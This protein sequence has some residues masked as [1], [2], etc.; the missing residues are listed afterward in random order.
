MNVSGKHLFLRIVSLCLTEA[1][2]NYTFHDVQ[3]S[4]QK[5]LIINAKINETDI[6]VFFLKIE[7]ICY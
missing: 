3:P 1:I 4:C 6:K 2:I 5:F 7:A